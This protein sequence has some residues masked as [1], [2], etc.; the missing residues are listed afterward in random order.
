MS[1][2]NDLETKLRE[3][4][5]ELCGRYGY[6]WEH[7]FGRELITEAASTALEHAAEIASARAASVPPVG[8]ALTPIYE[9]R[10]QIERSVA[11]GVASS[12]R[13][14]ARALGGKP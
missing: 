4:L 9:Q 14:A 13:A 5:C 3:Q 10:N 11:L 1:N 8:A 7:G 2:S 6:R 12:I